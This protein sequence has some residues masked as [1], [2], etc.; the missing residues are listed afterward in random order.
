M[1]TNPK[2]IV[3]LNSSFE[4]DENGNIKSTHII[5]GNI[6]DVVKAL[7]KVVIECKE[8]LSDYRNEQ[9]KK[10]PFED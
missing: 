7:H 4:M 9:D 3:K 2:N 1:S 10:H 5:D 8:R 6:S